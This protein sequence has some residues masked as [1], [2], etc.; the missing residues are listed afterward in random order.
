MRKIFLSLFLAFASIV[1]CNAQLL[2]KIS[3]KNLAKP[4]YIVG[5]YHLA[6]A[7]FVDSIP[8]ARDVLNAVDV[9]CGEVVMSEMES[10]ENEKKVKDAM[11]LPDGKSLADVLTADEMQRLNDYMTKIMG[12]NLENP[13]LKS[14][15]GKMTP[16]AISTQLQLVQYMKNTPKFNPL[17][18]IDN[19][20]QKAAKKAGKRVLGLETV[21]FQIKTLY[22][23]TSI[24]RQKEQL[25]CMVDNSEYYALQMKE[26]ARA[27][28]AQDMQA[29]WDLTEEKLGNSCDSTPEE[30]LALIY[31]RNA[32]WVEQ[33]PAMI[34]ENSILFVV[35]AAHL[36]GE[37]GVLELLKAKGYTVEAVK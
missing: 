36:P 9:V 26:L 7:S 31:G 21:D 18:L 2:Y 28:F 11:M 29:L 17:K 6:P 27:Y 33:I 19:Y 1:V 24:E 30:D 35:G 15:M 22:L 10:K 32:A 4:S 16:M 3:H 14:Q 13:I 25:F 5:T 23:G 12:V 34:S 20:F 37:Q 8:G